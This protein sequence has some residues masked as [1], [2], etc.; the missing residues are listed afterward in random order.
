M[1]ERKKEK[2]IYIRDIKLAMEKRQ[3]PN[4]DHL[5]HLTETVEFYSGPT[6]F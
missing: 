1:K 3:L 4:G 5:F 2:K 6:C